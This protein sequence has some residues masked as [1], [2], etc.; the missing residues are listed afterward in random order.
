M[1]PLII[2]AIENDDDR[3]FMITLYTDYYGLMR[4]HAYQIVED[5]SV[6]E[7]MIHDACIRLI[8]NIST[9]RTLKCC[10]L[11][12]YL[13]S[14]IRRVCLNYV[15][16]NNSVKQKEI[17]GLP[18]DFI[19]DIAD[20]S[21]SVEDSA[22]L[23]LD[24]ERLEKSISKLPQNYQDVLNFKYLLDMRDDEIAQTIGIQKNSVRQYLTRA[25]RK[26]LIVMKTEDR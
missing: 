13:V 10:V 5:N 19:D 17:F 9:V 22:L 8:N 23:Q 1:I 26:A 25:R 3:D 20:K 18:E 4:K 6:T 21:A 24:I 15:I 7:D 11:P 14:T 12:A 2:M 16:R